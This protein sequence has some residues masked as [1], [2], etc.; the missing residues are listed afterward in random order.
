MSTNGNGWAPRKTITVL[1]PS[2]KQPQ[3]RRPGPEFMLRNGR[4][5]RTFSKSLSSAGPRPGQSAEDYNSEVIEQMSDDELAALMVFARGLVCA[6]LVSPKL[7]LNPREDHDEIGPDDMPTTDFWFLFNYGME[8]FI[9]IKVPVG[10]GDTET[11]VEV[12]D[13][14]TFRPE[15]SVSGASVDGAPVSVTESEPA[16]TDSGLVHSTGA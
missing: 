1:C 3:V 9:G 14:E 4:V 11:E 12:T 13:L 2:G 7:V 10:E 15:S 8:N 6:M 16:I 5:A